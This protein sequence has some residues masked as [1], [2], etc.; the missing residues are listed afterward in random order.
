MTP[1]LRTAVL[2]LGLLSVGATATVALDAAASPPG[3]GMH[4]RG[5]GNHG[6]KMPGAGLAKLLAQLDLTEDQQAALD[7]LRD[8]VIAEMKAL[9]AERKASRGDLVEQLV[10]GELSRK[11]VHA[12]LDER[13]AAKAAM[14]H[15]IVDR[16]LDIH[17]SLSPDQLAELQQLLDEREARRAERMERREAMQADEAYDARQQRRRTRTR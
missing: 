9:H 1:S 13:A 12:M 15:D 11:Q 14:T 7:A 5:P 8:D 16:I 3:V 10:A 17:A 4:Q 6:P 2:A